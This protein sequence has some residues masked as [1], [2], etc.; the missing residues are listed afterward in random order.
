MQKVFVDTNVLMNNYFSFNDYT[1]VYISIS[2]IEELD[3]HKNSESKSYLTRK[4]IK[5]IIDSHN[6]EIVV[7]KTNSKVDVFLEHKK[8]N[9]ILNHALKT[10][11]ENKDNF[12]FL[13][14][15]YALIIKAKA[16][17]IPCEMFKFNNDKSNEIYTG[18]RELYLTD[19]EF[20]NL[21]NSTDNFYKLCPN[22]YLIVHNKTINDQFL[23]NWNGEY[24]EEVKV[25]PI[26]NKYES[27]ITYLD[28]YQK[29]FIHMLQNNK[30]KIKITDSVYGAGKSYL[31]I[32]WALQMLEK[33]KYN[34]LYFIKSDSP[35]K[36]RKEFPAI[37]GNVIEKCEPLLGV[38]CDVTSEYN[39]TDILLRNN[40][41]EILPIQFVKGRSIKNSII[42]VNEA[43]DFTPSEIERILSRLGEGSVVLLDGSTK[44]IDNKYC[45]YRN[46]L[47]VASCNYK[48]SKNA[49]QV[50]MINDYRSELSKEVS[51]MDWSD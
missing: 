42:Y 26:S 37:P 24:F 15:D 29:A 9:I 10:W 6:V 49:A 45:L 43:Q 51:E 17:G 31:M 50:N 23:Y 41:L 20:F 38:L 12:L 48:N 34:K 18:I 19:E 30:I 4:V 40:K 44:Q 7:D 32:N 47:S 13:C 28:I 33:E 22:E 11:E 14:D 39:I 46:G 27:K 8:D 35:P 25:K 5:K 2:S 36:N 3:N 1:K 21:I 16:L